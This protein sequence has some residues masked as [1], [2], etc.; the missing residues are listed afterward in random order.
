MVTIKSGQELI[1]KAKLGDKVTLKWTITNKSKRPWPRNL[2]VKN[3][4]KPD[5]DIPLDFTLQPKEEYEFIYEVQVP[6]Q[7]AK[8][9]FLTINL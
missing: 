7:E 2:L 4:T 9:R 8:D 6:E 1:T 5:S 3:F